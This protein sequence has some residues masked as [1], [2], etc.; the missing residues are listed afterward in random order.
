M[1]L[2]SMIPD[3]ELMNDDQIRTFKHTCLQTIDN[4]LSLNSYNN[5]SPVASVDSLVSQ[6]TTHR[7]YLLETPHT[8]RSVSDSASVTHIPQYEFLETCTSENSQITAADKYYNVVKESFT[9]NYESYNTH[10]S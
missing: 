10:Q 2:L 3:L 9:E 5:Y 8:S 7:S 6:A 4:I 1:F